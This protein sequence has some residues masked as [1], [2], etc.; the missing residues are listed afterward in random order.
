MRPISASRVLRAD[1]DAT[2]A[3]LRDL[4]R[5]WRIA[6]RWVDVVDL[7]GPVG[8]RTGGV[9]RVRGPLGLRRVVR[10][11]VAGL[12]PPEGLEGVARAGSRTEA[13]VT[14]RLEAAGPGA[15]RVELGVAVLRAGGPDRVLLAAGGR[16]WLRRHLATTLGRLAEAVE[17]RPGDA[18]AGVWVPA[19]AP[20]DA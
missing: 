20:A 4:D 16:L 11:T 13:R 7:E 10:T 19:Q 12:R 8:G 1:R 9:V 15:T 14:W 18:A 5:H 2:F 17:P 3:F 6:G